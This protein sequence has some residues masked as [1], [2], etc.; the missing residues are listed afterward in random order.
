MKKILTLMMAAALMIGFTACEKDDLAVE[1]TVKVTKYTSQA[2]IKIYDD[3]LKKI[4]KDVEQIIENEDNIDEFAHNFYESYFNS[5]SPSDQNL[6][7]NNYI[8][9]LSTRSGEE[10][11]DVNI[12]TNGLFERFAP[13]MCDVDV[14]LLYNEISLLYNESFFKELSPDLQT[15][16]EIQLETLKNSRDIMISFI[17]DLYDNKI[18][19]MSP[20]DRMVWSECAAQM[21]DEQREQFIETQLFSM[22]LVCSGPAA[23]I[24]AAVEFIRHIFDFSQA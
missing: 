3:M 19:R 20:G 18:T 12:L 14:N 22:S 9:K 5:L 7:R 16:L 10:I 23:A 13:F 24:V 15:A 8:E 11:E 2:Y 6:L 21:T 17:V 4:V 1:E